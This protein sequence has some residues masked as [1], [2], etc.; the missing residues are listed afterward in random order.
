MNDGN[1][2]N[3]T[4]IGA[5]LM[6]HGIA[7][8]FAA[9][10]LNVRLVDQTDGALDAARLRIDLGLDLLTEAGLLAAD[11]HDA[12]RSRIAYSTNL[13]AASANADLILEAVF[14]DLDLKRM[15][16]SEAASA[17][18]KH[19][20]FS[21]NTS[22]FMPSQLADATGRPDR[23]AIAH[24]FNPPYLLPLVEIVPAQEAGSH[25][26]E[27]LRA[28]YLRLG[29]RP[30]VIRKALPGFIA[31]RLQAALSREA[32]AL[33]QRG[34]ATPQ[35]IDSVIKHGFGRRLAVAGPFEVWEQIGWDLVSTIA[36][37]LFAE[38]DNSEGPSQLMIDAVARGDLGVKTG[39]GMYEWTPESAEALRLRI[40][41]ALIRLAQLEA[42]AAGSSAEVFA[43]SETGRRSDQQ[44][45]GTPSE[46]QSGDNLPSRA[47]QRSDPSR[48]ITIVGAGL[49][50]HGIALE[51]AAH[52]H[53]V[54][55]NDVSEQLLETAFERCE[56]G[57]RLLA[58]AGR[59]SPAEIA[60]ALSRISASADLAT[61]VADADLVIEA[62]SEDFA[63]KRRIFAELDRL[64]PPHT[65]LLSNTSTFLPSAIGEDTDRADQ[66]AGG[67]YF[68]PGY[69][70]PGV[71][72]IRGPQTSQETIDTVVTLLESI[73]KRPV[74]VRQEIQGF[75]V[76]RLQAAMFREALH[77][78]GAG[79]AT[80]PEIDEVVRSSFGRRLSV[81]G[82]FELRE[83]IGL[84]LALDISRQIIPSLD[85]SRTIPAVLS[86]MVRARDLG[87][88]TGRGFY[89]WTPETA[90]ALRLRIAT[91]LADMAGWPG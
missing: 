69:L 22:S 84:D 80:A 34:I 33:V 2:Q 44:E 26:I 28:L 54:T 9:H 64:C 45:S 91:A 21:S 73:G 12:A 4:V 23:F 31:N 39:R 71:E 13:A 56:Q 27:T 15:L 16:L 66:I 50:G 85:N 49:M 78:V 70:L 18:P 43:P 62:T 24:Y 38:I 53:T 82:T 61:A 51:F 5:G 25:V 40:G 58:S 90:E 65:I 60:P 1:I 77:I 57:L 29:K 59:I 86:D 87:T 81:A 20:I 36:G 8:E 17:A 52:G 68:N 14:E 67:H 83:L 30:V 35:D 11:A 89:D 19:A 7:L 48:K 6:G 75:I 10:G 55:I 41:R 74:V 37:E 42:G 3:V 76:N 72:V 79:V 46:T 47:S 32:G 88:K 63:L